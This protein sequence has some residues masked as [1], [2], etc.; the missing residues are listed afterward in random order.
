MKP[1]WFGS[2]EWA[3]YMAMDYYGNWWWF[4]NKPE[5]GNHTWIENG[6]RSEELGDLGPYW[7]DSLEPRP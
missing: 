7:R 6:G 2:P 5:L 4:E 1:D 3:N